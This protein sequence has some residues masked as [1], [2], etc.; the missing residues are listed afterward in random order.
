[1]FRQHDTQSPFSRCFRCPNGCIHLTCGN[2][3][4]NLSPTEFLVLAEAVNAMRH[5]LREEAR[6]AREQSV[7]VQTNSFTM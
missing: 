7:Q 1:M 3:T 4:V 2:L 6:S 5:E